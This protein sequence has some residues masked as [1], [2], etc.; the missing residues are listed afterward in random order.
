MGNRH[1]ANNPFRWDQIQ[2]NLPTTERYDPTFPWVAKVRGNGTLASDVFLYVANVRSSGD[3]K[4]DC[5]QALRRFGSKCNHLSIQDAPQK[6]KPLD[7]EQGPWAGSQIHT[8]N[9]VE[10]MLPR[11]SGRS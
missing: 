7:Q 11:T 1:D 6:H 8:V 3:T 2:L 5:H 10:A 9:G 4:E